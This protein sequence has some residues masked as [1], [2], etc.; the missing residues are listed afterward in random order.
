MPL[1]KT[2]RFAVGMIRHPKQTLA[3]VG[4]KFKR[5]G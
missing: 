2:V 4:S 5:Q 3:N 1:R